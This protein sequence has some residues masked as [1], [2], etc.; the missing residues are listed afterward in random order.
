MISLASWALL[1]LAMAQPRPA[2]AL[3]SSPAPELPPDSALV[4]RAKRDPLGART[5][6]NE[7]LARAVRGSSAART[8]EIEAA[9]R[10]ATAYAAAWRDSLLVRQVAR[11]AIA[12]PAWQRGKVRADSLRRSGSDAYGRRGPAAAIEVWRR[13]LAQSAAVYDSVG[14]GATL[15]NIGAGF[16]RL[17]RADSA[18][19]YLERA[20]TIAASIGDIRVEANARAE[21]A[22]VSEALGNI[23]AARQG[24]ASVLTLRERIGDTRGMAADYNNIGLLAERLGDTDEARRAFESALALNQREGRDLVSATNLVNLAGLASMSGEFS[25]AGTL[26]GQALRTWRANAQWVDAAD[27]LRG[28]GQLELRRGDY[29]A[30][31]PLLSEAIATYDRSGLVDEALEARRDRAAALAGGGRLQ[32][33]LDE[34]RRAQAVVDSA[35]S[36]PAIRAEVALARADLAAH[37][38]ARAESERLYSYAR[39]L[40]RGA[41]DRAGEA[42]AEQG[43]GLLLLD[44]EDTTHARPLL[45]A[46]LS[47]Q[48]A[49]ENHRAAAV[50]RMF[51]GQLALERGDTAGA[52]EIVAKA[53]SDL[54]DLGDPVASATALGELATLR[55]VAGL[56]SAAESLYTDALARVGDRVAPHATWRLHAG[57]GLLRRRRG[58]LVEAARELRAAVMDVERAGGSLSLPERRSG[59]LADKTDAYLQLALAERALGRTSDAFD[60]SERVR[61][62]EMLDLL[63][64]GRVSA[65]QDTAAELVAREQDL[66][67][68][69]A[70]LTR[71]IEGV[72]EGRRP[73]RGRN[74]SANAR[75]TREALVHAQTAYSELLLEMVERVPRYASLVSSPQSRSSWRDV[76]RHVAPDEA[77]I[78]YLVSDSTSVAFVITRD[79]IVSVELGGG[80]SRQTL[81]RSIDFVRGVLTPRGSP[82]LD[83]LWR[84]PLSRLHGELIAPLER[85]GALAGR[86]RL[87]IVP[88]GD[89]HYLPFAALRDA[90]TGRYLVE[91]YEIAVAPSA[92]VWLALGARQNDGASSG[93]LALAPHPEALPAS[94]R[95]VEAVGRLAGADA[96]VLIG[97]LATKDAFRREASKYRVLH[98]ATNGVLNKTNPLFSFVEL[99][100][101]ERAGDDGRLEVHDVFGLRLTADMVVLSACQTALGS[102]TRSDVPAGDDW[103]GLA[104]A[105]LHAGASRVV[106]SLWPVQ[107]RA[108][109]M[110]MEQF[111]GAYTGG[112]APAS[113]LA[114]AQRAALANPRTAHPFYWAAFEVIGQR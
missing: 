64:L 22:G 62:R 37:L 67:R 27:A 66:R 12:T 36:L 70:E 26:Y 30:A 9:G 79:T 95:E 69:I 101:D 5:A 53:A 33:A 32:N 61:A 3:R 56:P 20:R 73:L 75:V 105:F 100:P 40:F 82:R 51:L 96:R 58:M 55:M 43:L 81:S 52:Q 2:G 103:V 76:S 7:L 8:R 38:N 10:L 39:Q 47:G 93:V 63:A 31:I 44:A 110:L 108:T 98:L 80:S 91:R 83:S 77:F 71:Q 13:A 72:D 42:E 15:G 68:H 45:E 78:E 104:R 41:G 112:A 90:A 114:T 54:E 92:A 48:L 59:Y 21:L 89:L 107:D 46:A 49:A 109:S 4:A 35:G 102:G 24:Y 17:G 6:V 97:R 57:L 29:P 60:V 16:A 14:L 23:A 11:F 1:S 25:R 86:K 94:R 84:A 87:I 19:V 74:V 65:P 113:A 99:A 28:L 18:V 111:Y 50:T 106:A 85:T 34:L 88:H